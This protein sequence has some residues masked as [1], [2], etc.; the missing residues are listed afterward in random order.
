MGRNHLAHAAGDA[1]LA[2]AGYNFRRLLAWLAVFLRAWIAPL[3]EG[4]AS[5]RNQAAFACSR[6]F[7]D[8]WG[9][10]PKP[11]QLCPLMPTRRA[12]R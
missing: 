3:I 8:D 2:A 12:F 11:L 9:Y 7:T 10:Q 6:F 1:A 4:R 5:S